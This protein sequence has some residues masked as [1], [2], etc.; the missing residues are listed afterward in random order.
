MGNFRAPLITSTT[1]IVSPDAAVNAEKCIA[2]EK[3]G[4]DEILFVFDYTQVDSNV[5]WKYATNG[6]RD[7]EYA[8]LDIDS[9]AFKAGGDAAFVS[10]TAALVT[11]RTGAVVAD[12]PSINLNKV[13]SIDKIEVPSY[14]GVGGKVLYKLVFVYEGVNQLRE[15]SWSYAAAADRDTTYTELTAVAGALQYIV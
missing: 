8:L 4:T 7:T 13:T 2:I 11:D 3:Q 14:L 10:S 6:N 1:A 9:A 5:V 15:L 12:K